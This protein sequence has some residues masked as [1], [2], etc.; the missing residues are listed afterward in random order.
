M[1]RIVQVSPTRLDT[2]PTELLEE[3]ITHLVKTERDREW[4]SDDQSR[5]QG[6][7]LRPLTSTSQCAEAT[8]STRKWKISALGLLPVLSH[9]SIV[10]RWIYP[11]P[12]YDPQYADI[13]HY[14]LTNRR[15]A[16]AALRSFV[17]HIETHPWDFKARSLDRVANLLLN[18]EIATRVTC[19]WFHSFRIS[20]HDQ[21]NNFGP[22]ASTRNKEARTEYISINLKRQL[23]VIFQRATSLKRLVVT[24]ELMWMAQNDA[25]RCEQASQSR[26]QTHEAP[27]KRAGYFDIPNPLLHL[28]T[29]LEESGMNNKLQEMTV[30][31]HCDMDFF[32]DAMET[33]LPSSLL[34]TRMTKLTIEPTQLMNQEFRLTCPRLRTLEILNLARLPRWRLS[35]LYHRLSKLDYHSDLERQRVDTMF[36][37]PIHVILSGS[38]IPNATRPGRI[39]TSTIYSL[40]GYI[41]KCTTRIERVTTSHGVVNDDGDGCGWVR[42]WADTD[43]HGKLLDDVKEMSDLTIGVLELKAVTWVESE[44]SGSAVVDKSARR[45]GEEGVVWQKLGELER[46]VRKVEF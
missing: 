46:F 37:N 4:T 45:L 5:R 24:P 19:L 41:S 26:T 20:T 44:Q 11:T 12:V 35:I 23:L 6:D 17:D 39:S 27:W 28:Q 43:E 1:A 32:N 18:K 3:I 25:Q 38:T 15:A 21:G 14:R 42:S 30:Y 8:S 34:C 10:R 31:T 36:K 16:A 13:L 2:L 22:A 29:A 7:H 9:V 33:P 40:V